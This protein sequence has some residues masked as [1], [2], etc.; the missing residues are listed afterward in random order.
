MDKKDQVRNEP[1]W[2]VAHVISIKAS[3]DKRRGVLA[4][5]DGKVPAKLRPW[6]ESEMAELLG[7]TFL[8]LRPA[9]MEIAREDFDH[10]T[11][12]YPMECFMGQWGILYDERTEEAT[13]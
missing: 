7:W 9:S 2:R 4:S 8:F 10:Y 6:E 5:G 12:Y 11:A 1:D 3:N 13:A